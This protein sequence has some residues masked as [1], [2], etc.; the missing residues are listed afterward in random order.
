MRLKKTVFTTIGPLF[1]LL[2][3][4]FTSIAGY[5]QEP[6]RQ[7]PPDPY[8]VVVPVRDAQ[9]IATDLDNA[10]V[11]RQLAIYRN[12]QAVG[13]LRQIASAI[14]TRESSVDDIKDRKDDA[15]D[16]N[17]KS[18][19]TS[20]KVEEKANK[21]AIDLLKRLRGLREAEVDVAKSEE[22]HADMSIRVLQ[23]ES[24]MQ[25]KRA[26]HNWPSIAGTGNLTQNTAYQILAKLEMNLLELQKD[27]ASETQEVASKQ[28]HVVDQRMKLHKAQ[29]ELGL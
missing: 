14:D 22:D 17:R 8:M 27:L 29:F 18:E 24:E 4:V 15:K 6:Q 21:K 25:Q 13:R 16:D 19:E 7:R 23:L 20:L 9:E 1:V 10:M 26:E 3:M 11:T 2:A 12:T 28:K 5:A